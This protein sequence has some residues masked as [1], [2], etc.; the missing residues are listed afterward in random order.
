MRFL[1]KGQRKTETSGK[2]ADS[3]SNLELLISSVS[4]GTASK[5]LRTMH[6]WHERIQ[7]RRHTEIAFELKRAQR[8]NSVS[9]WK[10]K[11]VLGVNTALP[12]PA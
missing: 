2:Q 12:R 4:T 6:Y 1:G 10:G 11:A 5:D 7:K 9:Q 8:L 3:L